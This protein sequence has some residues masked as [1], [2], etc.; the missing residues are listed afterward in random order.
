MNASAE[1]GEREGREVKVSCSE[2]ASSDVGYV[3][4]ESGPLIVKLSIPL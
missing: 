1:E 3:P 2:K 4:A